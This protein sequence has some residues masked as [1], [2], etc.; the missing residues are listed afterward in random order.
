MEKHSSPGDVNEAILDHI[1]S[2]MGKLRDDDVHIIAA[3]EF[4][5]H[6]S[7]K[8]VRSAV[9]G[10]TD[11]DVAHYAIKD[12]SNHVKRMGLKDRTTVMCR[13]YHDGGYHPVRTTEDIIQFYY[14][15]GIVNDR[16]GDGGSK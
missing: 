2:K 7:D 4:S 5:D 9:V 15:I 11:V 1:F 13:A 12:I 6:H 10:N 3:D 14:E 8:W 16:T